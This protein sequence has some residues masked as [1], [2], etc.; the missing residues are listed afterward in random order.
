MDGISGGEIRH[1]HE[2][3]CS[4]HI[5]PTIDKRRFYASERIEKEFSIMRKWDPESC[6]ASIGNDPIG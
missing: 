1:T 5:T 4:P 6:R 2:I 3:E